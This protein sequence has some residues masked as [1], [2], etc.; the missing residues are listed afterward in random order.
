[1]TPFAS[2]DVDKIGL[3]VISGI[4][5]D[6]FDRLNKAI[7][8]S[9]SHGIVETNTDKARTENVLTRAFETLLEFG[10]FYRG[11]A[12]EL[13]CIRASTST[14]ATRLNSEKVVKK[15]YNKVMMYKVLGRRSSDNKRHDT[16]RLVRRMIT[17]KKNKVLYML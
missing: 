17:S 9:I 6:K 14:A 8:V 11:H 1:M 16:T 3:H 5:G 13:L 7:K 2:D 15:S 4:D 10:H 12:K